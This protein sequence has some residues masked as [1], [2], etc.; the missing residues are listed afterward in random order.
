MFISYIALATGIVVAF[1]LYLFAGRLAGFS[2]T[3]L[4]SMGTAYFLM[5]PSYSLHVSNPHDWAALALYGA[6]GLVMARVTPVAGAAPIGIRQ[7]SQEFQQRSLELVN[8]KDVLAD[9]TASSDLG[10]L[11]RRRGIEVDVSGLQTFPCSYADAVSVLSYV[12][13]G[14]LI[15]PQLRRISV[16][17]ARRPEVAL[18]FVWANTGPLPLRETITIG[19][20]ADNSSKA[21][22]SSWPTYMSATWFD[23]GY[24]RIYQISR[25]LDTGLTT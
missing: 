12:V 3:A 25:R 6:V 20:C 23:S 24:G 17:I 2:A 16:Q 9:L 21:V 7:E 22:F 8:I 13:A 5:P 14:V 10:E 1:C 15:E 19:K 11:L 4:W 18:L